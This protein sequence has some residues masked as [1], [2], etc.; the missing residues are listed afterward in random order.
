MTAATVYGYELR[1]R[2]GAGAESGRAGLRGNC[3]C[4][5]RDEFNALGRGLRVASAQE[6]QPRRSGAGLD[7]S[8][9]PGRWSARVALLQSPILPSAGLVEHGA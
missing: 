1:R 8:A 4:G 5:R 3:K 7:A 6:T 9:I 2:R